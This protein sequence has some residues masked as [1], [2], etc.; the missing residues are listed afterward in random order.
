MI[1][2]E[3]K[4]GFSRISDKDVLKSRP[5]AVSPDEICHEQESDDDSD[6][7]WFAESK[8]KWEKWW[9]KKQ[10][11]LC[12]KCRLECKQSWRS[13]VSRC[14]QYEPKEAKDNGD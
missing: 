6:I 1:S 13:K 14:P 10:N 11:Q 8:I 12:A 9:W 5:T 3:N 4:C 2:Q 7:P